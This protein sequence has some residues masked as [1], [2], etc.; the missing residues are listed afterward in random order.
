MNVVGHKLYDLFII[1]QSKNNTVIVNGPIE[2][3]MYREDCCTRLEPEQGF[4]YDEQI[5]T[6]KTQY[7][8]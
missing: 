5:V 1:D 3:G 7:T 8:Q 2:D 4:F 6:T